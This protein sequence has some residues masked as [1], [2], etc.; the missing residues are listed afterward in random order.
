VATPQNAPLLFP[1]ESIVEE[2]RRD[3]T[4]RSERLVAVPDLAAVT[5]SSRRAAWRSRLAQRGL[6]ASVLVMGVAGALRLVFPRAYD[7]LGDEIYYVDLSSSIRAHHYPPHFMHEGVFLLHP[8]L[9]FLTGAF[10]QFIFGASSNYF[11]LIVSMRVLEA[12]FAIAT[13]G[14]IVGIG[15]RLANWRVGAVAG[16][17]FALDPYALRVNSRV[18]LET[19]AVAFVLAGYFVLLSL[20][21][22]RRTRLG[23]SIE[24]PARLAT[25]T[26]V[27]AGLLFGLGIVTLELDVI[28][29]LL[30]LAIVFWRNW[31]IERRLVAITFVVA[32]VPYLCY[33]V[34]LALTH[35][36]SAFFDQDLLGFKRAI[37]LVRETGF[38]ATNAPS[39]SSTL[40]SQAPEFGTTYLLAG[41]AVLCSI[42]PLLRRRGDLR[43]FAV[44]TL[45]GALTIAYDALFGTVEEQFLYILVVPATVAVPCAIASSL[46]AARPL[47]RRI[48][49]PVASLAVA[50]VA[51]YNLG[52]W[53]HVRSRPDTGLTAVTSFI[54]AKVPHRPMVGTNV[55]VAT[56][57]FQHEGIRAVTI[58]TPAQARKKHVRYLTILSAELKGNYGSMTE[59]NAKWFEQHG[60]LV[61]SRSEATYDDVLLYETNDPKAW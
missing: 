58:S 11:S 36:L 34:S 39:L 10:W 8:P 27:G 40:I 54:K 45:A 61:F 7:V 26:A 46:A 38:N 2:E 15:T 47:S 41:G 23:A 5:K 25:L 55:L 44:V 19:P 56:Y 59:K 51:C 12:I 6:L 24:A 1:G 49:R 22:D 31:C 52:V 42:H 13:A 18:L 9:F 57:A 20:T 3:A 60:H 30:P 37:G 53:I 17:L 21:R 33:L 29:T 50:L 14:L 16:A 28:I 48:L 43:L 32:V 4:T 35:N